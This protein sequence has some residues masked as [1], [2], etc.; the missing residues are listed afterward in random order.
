MPLQLPAFPDTPRHSYTVTLGDRQYVCH[1][2]WR[3][4]LGSWHWT[5]ETREGEPLWRGLR[6]SPGERPGL[7]RQ[8]D[9]LPDGVFLVAGPDPYAREDFGDRLLVV[10]VP[11]DEIPEA[12]SSGPEIELG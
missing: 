1:F 2:T 6:L 10:F 5:L 7:G 9:R 4:R 3:R 12:E 11:D 8:G